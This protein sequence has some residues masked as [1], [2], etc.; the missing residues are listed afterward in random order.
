MKYFDNLEMFDNPAKDLG[1]GDF[2]DFVSSA[3]K[4]ELDEY[5]IRDFAEALAQNVK[6]ETVWNIITGGG[7]E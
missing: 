7:D 5:E 1:H 3:S 6:E 2:L 4:G